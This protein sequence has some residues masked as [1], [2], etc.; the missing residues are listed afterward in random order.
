MNIMNWIAIKVLRKIEIWTSSSKTTK[1]TCVYEHFQNDEFVQTFSS[2]YNSHKPPKSS[3]SH[4]HCDSQR[5][6][7]WCWFFYGECRSVIMGVWWDLILSSACVI[8]VSAV[9]LAYHPLLLYNCSQQLLPSSAASP[10]SFISLSLYLCL[11]HVCAFDSK[12]PG[13]LFHSLFLF[14][15][16]LSV[17][18]DAI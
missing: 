4:C 2:L 14:L 9:L 18:E 8:S 15:L 12:E 6:W 11:P 16:H 3:N 1:Q 17:W 5:V 7:V 10:P 13:V